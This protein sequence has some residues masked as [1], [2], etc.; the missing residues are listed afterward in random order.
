MEPSSPNGSGTKKRRLL[1]GFAVL[2]ALPTYLALGARLWWVLDLATHFC[3]FYA[4]ALLPIAVALL[5]S[6]R[7]RLL[8]FVSAALAINISLLAPLYFRDRVPTD[9]QPLRIVSINVLFENPQHERVLDCIRQETPD[10]VLLMEV[11]ASWQPALTTLKSQFPYSLFETKEGSFGIALFSKLPLEN[12]QLLDFGSIGT[13]SIQAT[14]RVD[15]TPV[16]IVG[17][18]FIPPMN[19]EK[20]RLRNQYLIAA[21]QELARTPGPR[22]LLGDLNITPWSPYFRDLLKLGGLRNSQIGFGIQPTWLA[23]LP[24]DH[25]LHSDDVAILDRRIGPDVGSDHR[26]LIVDFAVK[27]TAQ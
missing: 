17:A 23:A 1:V 10:L 7:W 14:V 22:L 26:P 25:L 4:F 8:A 2:A 20:S 9:T 19:G 21:A 15:G 3:A 27:K 12:L 11:N 13:P 18:H 16:Q 24:I 5:V 6:K